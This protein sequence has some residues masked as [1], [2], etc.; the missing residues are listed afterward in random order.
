MTRTDWTIEVFGGDK[1]TAGEWNI[2]NLSLTLRSQAAD[3][4]KF[5][6]P[7]QQ[8]ETAM[9]F[10]YETKLTLRKQITNLD[11]LAV[12][13][14]VYFVGWV[15][16][17]PQEQ[18][19]GAEAH[20]YTV[21]GP[22]RWL[23]R[24]EYMQKWY[25]AVDPSNPAS[26]LVGGY[27][28]HVILN[29]GVNG[30]FL[31]TQEQ[32]EDVIDFYTY[33]AG[34]QTVPVSPELQKAN[35]YPGV[36]IP[37]DEHEDIMCA[38]VIKKQLRWMPDAV[39]WFDYTTSPPTLHI[40]RRPDLTAKEFKNG[41][42]TTGGDIIM[43]GHLNPR[44]DLQVPG[45]LLKY[46]QT[47]QVN[48]NSWQT[49]TPDAYP[50]NTNEVGFGVLVM[51]IPLQGF[52]VQYT[53]AQVT[54]RTMAFS[55]LGYG[56][57]LEKL[58]LANTGEVDVAS[59]GAVVDKVIY[60]DGSEYDYNTGVGV[61]PALFN[62]IVEGSLTPGWW[63]KTNAPIAGVQV[64]LQSYTLKGTAAYKKVTANGVETAFLRQPFNL[65]V[66]ATNA[67]TG[68]W[69]KLDSFQA[70]DPI[71]TG[72]AEAYYNA[73]NE[74]QYD[75][76]FRLAAQEIDNT[77]IGMGNVVNVTNGDAAWATMRSLVQQVTFNIDA[78]TTQVNIGVAKH[79]GVGDLIQLLMVN[80][81]RERWTAP[82]TQSSG[83]VSGSKVTNPTHGPGQDTD[84]AHEGVGKMTMRKEAIANVNDAA[85]IDQIAK[86]VFDAEN[87]A[88]NLQAKKTEATSSGQ[89]EPDSQVLIELSKCL[90]K[91]LYI[92]EI[93]VCVEGVDKK[94]LFLC[95]DPYDPQ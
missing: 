32:L 26:S 73:L 3:E 88:F 33:A 37:K 5:T 58:G 74:L 34:Q 95:S 60:P 44:H 61:P 68:T 75:G 43:Q 6:M 53:E 65:R 14:T 24:L 17:H 20:H 89:V 80:R 2:R 62:D 72:L 21:R 70:G 28:S 59:F 15:E 25:Q 4:L 55:G 76:S 22:W 8:W 63:N 1:K 92:R 10:P 47:N 40:K 83:Q 66:N 52:S 45:V 50:A 67:Y 11:T 79:L 19:A 57:L 86:M 38:E 87:L 29:Q 35:D 13:E 41:D 23:E 51:T 12:T 39:T 78:G 56:Y 36:E 54:T 16:Q 9:V 30:V 84:K 85:G 82:G 71:P 77:V 27:L 93:D 18:G 7:V 42:G 48:G 49:T 64:D 91:K 69:Q 94:A 90:G 31:N 81:T 46:Q